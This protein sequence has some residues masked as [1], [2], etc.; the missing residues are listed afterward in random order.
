MHHQPK[1]LYI[2]VAYES[3]D[4]LLV[5]KDGLNIGLSILPMNLREKIQDL[6]FILFRIFAQKMKVTLATMIKN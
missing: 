3:F 2:T 1:E 4:K 5:A 6:L